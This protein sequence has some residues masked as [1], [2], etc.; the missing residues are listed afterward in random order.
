VALVSPAGQTLYNTQAGEL[1]DAR[2]MGEAGIHDFFAKL[3]A[4]RTN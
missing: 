4:L 2:N 3:A 1:A